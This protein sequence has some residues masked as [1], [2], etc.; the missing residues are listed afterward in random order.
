MMKIPWWDEEIAD[1]LGSASIGGFFFYL[2]FQE[3]QKSSVGS[4]APGKRKRNMRLQ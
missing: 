4:L 2:S 1:R 3:H